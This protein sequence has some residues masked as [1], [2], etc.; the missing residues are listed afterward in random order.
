MTDQ[1]PPGGSYPP[2]PPPPGPSGGSEPP[3]GGY[4]TPPAP[5]APGAGGYLSPPPP[6]P[7][8][9]TPGGSG[10]PPPPPPPEGGY[11]PPPPPS[12]GG[13]AP[14][15]PGPAVRALPTESY[16]PWITRVLAALIDWA[17]YV[18]LTGI[19]W[20]IMM[21]TTT[22]SCVT[23]ISQY[24]IGQYCVSQPSMIGQVAQWLMSL[25]GLAY[26]VWDYGYR[27]GTTGSSIGKSVLK[28]K[29]VSEA[30]GEPLGF[31]MSVVRQ[32]AHIVDA[33]ICYIGFLFPLWDAK[34][35]TLADKIMTTVCLPL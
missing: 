12:A 31:G 29:V 26:L 14:P 19:G 2:P 13:Y 16:T 30:T 32:L 15:P 5:S 20:L 6:P 3:S 35:Q 8:R 34:R 9:P 21:V 23:D 11:P 25:V 10:Y 7:P 1:P 17:P 28:F 33:I 24:D 18:L 22:S 27:Q 4:Q